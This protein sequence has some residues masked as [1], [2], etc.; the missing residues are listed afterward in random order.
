MWKEIKERERERAKKQK[1]NSRFFLLRLRI[2]PR[3]YT[4]THNND[5]K[6][7]SSR[8]PVD[9]RLDRKIIQLFFKRA[10]KVLLFSPAFLPG[11][12]T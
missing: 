5:I 7:E 1:K 6:W 10:A 9:R 3:V 12:M 8:S 4:H 11:R 2:S